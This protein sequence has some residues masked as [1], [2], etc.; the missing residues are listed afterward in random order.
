MQANSLGTFL[1]HPGI[2]KKTA[3][4]VAAI[5]CVNFLIRR[6]VYDIYDKPIGT[7]D[8]NV[9]FYTPL[10]LCLFSLMFSKW[11]VSDNPY[12]KGFWFFFYCLSANWVFRFAFNYPNVMLKSEYIWM[13]VFII[14]TVWQIKTY[15]KSI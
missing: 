10:S 7:L 13:G 8:P 5:G 9:Y 1:L 3:N 11:W 15:K 4:W 14:H 2:K 12:W 6:F